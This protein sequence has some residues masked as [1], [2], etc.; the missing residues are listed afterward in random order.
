MVTF[1]TESKKTTKVGILSRISALIASAFSILIIAPYLGEAHFATLAIFLSLATTFSAL[2]SAGLDSY[3]VSYLSKNS[4]DVVKIAIASLMIRFFILLVSLFILLSLPYQINYI[5]IL[6]MVGSLRVFSILDTLLIVYSRTTK[7]II[8]TL[9]I[10]VFLFFKLML[11]FRDKDLWWFIFVIF[12]ENF[13]RILVTFFWGYFN[14]NKNIAPMTHSSF[15]KTLDHA[16]EISLKVPMLLFIIFADQISTNL[17]LFFSTDS[18]QS[19]GAPA[20]L[21][22]LYRLYVMFTGVIVI[23]FLGNFIS[24]KG[25]ELDDL[26]NGLKQY[27]T[28]VITIAGLA[29]LTFPISAMLIVYIVG[30]ESQNNQIYLLT[31]QYFFI[32]IQATVLRV[33]YQLNTI[34]EITVASLIAV[35]IKLAFLLQ[36][37]LSYNLQVATTNVS[38]FFSVC[39]L[40]LS[41]NKAVRNV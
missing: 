27:L 25:N 12:L 29:T 32:S 11:V 5:E 34:K 1:T 16:N 24:Q 19:L 14:S 20:L 26:A 33:A 41:V 9:I 39:F 40:S 15:K 31:V 13:F 23:S 21:E 4:L 10:C 3:L 6:V 37:D 22:R 7:F 17:N 35:L 38:I 8:E 30:F 28:N 2:V 18:T 36:F